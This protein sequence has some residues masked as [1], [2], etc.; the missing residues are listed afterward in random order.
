[1]N[2]VTDVICTLLLCKY[3]SIDAVYE[4]SVPCVSY[5][6][7]TKI[8]ESSE[9]FNLHNVGVVGLPSSLYDIHQRTDGNL[10]FTLVRIHNMQLIAWSTYFDLGGSTLCCLV[11]SPKT[12]PPWGFK[13]LLL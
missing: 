10:C 12:I 13:P 6:K 11:F 7:I 2:D 4:Y 9:I 5:K 8:I 1:M 3:P